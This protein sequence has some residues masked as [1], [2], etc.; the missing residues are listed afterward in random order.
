ML[1]YAYV[2]IFSEVR[3][4]KMGKSV[5][6][7]AVGAASVLAYQKYS[8]P[9]MDKMEKTANKALKKADKKLENMM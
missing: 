1:L 2:H 7:M 3:K 4:M 6:L 9:V 5:A 8:K